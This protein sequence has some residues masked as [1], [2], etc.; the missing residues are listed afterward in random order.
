MPRS[1]TSSG[2]CPSDR[3]LGASAKILSAGLAA[4]LLPGV[5]LPST[6]ASASGAG[7]DHAL[8]APFDEVLDLYVRDGFVYYRAL[9]A[10]RGKLDRY[11]AAL[12]V[13]PA[14]Y[15]AW[16]RAQQLAFWINAFNAFV[17]RIVID[18]YPIRGPSGP[19][20]PDSI[21]QIPGAFDRL[22][23]R[24]A[25]RRVT[26][27]EI[28][29]TILPG[30]D[31]PRV[32]FAL[33]RGAVGS[34]RLRSEAFVAARLE[35]QLQAATRELVTTP[36]HLHVDE[37][38]DEL[39]VTPVIGWHEAEFARKFGAATDGPFASRSAIERAILALV[40]PYLL[41]RERAVLARNT[42]SVRYLPFDW[43]LNDLTGR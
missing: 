26:L 33:G 41:P 19:Y 1:S 32:Y 12:D 42:F 39:Q 15:D 36:Q 38:A 14:T 31:D 40:D 5:L 7:Q 25:G 23:H 34:P 29:Y 8:H 24:A 28:E 27:D 21:R 17:L 2:R 6:A 11:L 9:K 37:A 4:C 22:R 30:F 35:S 3:C 43:R 16:P 20:P 13:A 10:D 18:H